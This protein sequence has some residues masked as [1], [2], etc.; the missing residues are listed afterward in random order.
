METPK[1]AILVESKKP[2][3]LYLDDIENTANIGF[4]YGDG[5]KGFVCH[6][7]NDGF[8]PIPSEMGY[9]VCNCA[10]D[11]GRTFKSVQA[12]VKSLN[13]VGQVYQFNTRKD[14]YKWL[15]E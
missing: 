14:L 2:K 12:A 10:Y 3:T 1:N 9:T 6:V 11:N 4:D 8:M 5:E 15:S 7:G 13:R